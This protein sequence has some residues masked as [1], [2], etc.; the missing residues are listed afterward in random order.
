MKKKSILSALT[1]LSLL[2]TISCGRENSSSSVDSA[3]DGEVTTTAP[4]ATGKTVITMAALHMDQD[5]QALI[6]DFNN[7]NELYAV[8]VIDYYTEDDT[9]KQ[10]RFPILLRIF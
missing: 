4:E 3:P 10:R 8:N 7:S 2:C 5:I 9:L 1:A 6:N